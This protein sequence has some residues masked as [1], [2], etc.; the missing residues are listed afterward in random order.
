MGED[1]ASTDG[2][3]TGRAERPGPCPGSLSALALLAVVSILAGILVAPGFGAQALPQLRPEDVGRPLESFSAAGFKAARDYDLPDAAL[4][5]RRR[6]EARAGVRPVFDFNPSVVPEERAAV[7]EAFEELRRTL[8]RLD[9]EPAR[10][11]ESPQASHRQPARPRPRTPGS[12]SAS[13]STAPRS[14]RPGSASSCGSSRST[15]T[16]GGHWSTPALL[17]RW[18]RPRWRSWSAASSP[19]WW[20]P[21]RTSARWARRSPCAI[22]PT[23]R[24]T[25]ARSSAPAV[26][27]VREARVEMDRW[28]SLPGQ[29]P[30]RRAAAAPPRGAAHR[31][32]RAAARPDPQHRRDRAAPQR[33]RARG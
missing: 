13:T 3:A 33:G 8:A 9:A 18:S 6:Q 23:A 4:T 24:S 16:T 22:S 1:T 5:E 26:L 11:A 32:A 14:T 15:T 21:A 17:P 19:R 7:R 2:S 20:A 25:P 31:Q 28:A 12:A 10:P 27:D 30:A 29:P